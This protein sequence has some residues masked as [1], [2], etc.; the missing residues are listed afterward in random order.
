MRN[1]ILASALLV[2][3][4]GNGFGLGSTAQAGFC[5]DSL[6]ANPSQIF[7]VSAPSG[8]GK[9]TL[10][11]RVMDE[12]PGKFFVSISTTT[13]SPRPGEV[14]GVDYNFV[15]V[16][17]FKKMLAT[18]E[19]L[20]SAEVHGNFYGTSK[21][22]IDQNLKQGRSVFLNINIEGAKNVR[23][24]YPGQTFSIF[25]APPSMQILEQRLRGRGTDP[26]EAIQKRLKNAREEMSHQDEFDA[27]VVNDKIDQATI[28]LRNLVLPNKEKTVTP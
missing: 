17:E 22:V 10:I 27:I 7:I 19:F 6:A 8:A 18:G 3:L 21:K 26:E 1:F 20:E 5:S 23:E 16:P 25:I 28:A 11:K 13:R 14:N 2:I 4:A 24:I 15:T 12:N 9:T